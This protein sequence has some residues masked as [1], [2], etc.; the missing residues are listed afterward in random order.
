[1]KT[2]A[3]LLA[4][5][6]IT[7]VNVRATLAESATELKENGKRLA[8]SGDRIKAIEFLEKSAAADANDPETFFLL[9]VN[10]MQLHQNEKGTSAFIRLTHLA[11]ANPEAHHNLGL[12]LASQNKIKEAIEQYDFAITLAGAS[13]PRAWINSR[14]K[15]AAMTEG[16]SSVVQNGENVK[17]EGNMTLKAKSPQELPEKMSDAPKS[18]PAAQPAAITAVQPKPVAAPSGSIVKS[19]AANFDDSDM[20]FEGSKRVR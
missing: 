18:T 17:I 19:S 14:N 4:T 16:A 11:P 6:A 1:M 13:A 7:C 9:G 10:Y 8:T 12:A 3:V 2:T 5:L 20:I 15:L